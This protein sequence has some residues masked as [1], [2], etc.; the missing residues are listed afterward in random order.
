VNK[1]RAQAQLLKTSLTLVRNLIEV[2]DRLKHGTFG[3][4]PKLEPDWDENCPKIAVCSG[5]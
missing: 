5:V 2:K 1:E 4:W 3:L